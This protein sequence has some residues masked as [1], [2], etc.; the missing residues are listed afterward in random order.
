MP[1]SADYYPREHLLC[2]GFDAEIPKLPLK[3][4]GV[5]VLAPERKAFRPGQCRIE[6]SVTNAKIASDMMGLAAEV[7]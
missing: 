5:A 1:A 2:P 6:G 7:G 3:G 4:T